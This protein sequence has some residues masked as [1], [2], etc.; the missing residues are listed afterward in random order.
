MRRFRSLS[1]GERGVR[2]VEIMP[3]H[4][5]ETRA[6][7]IMQEEREG[8][9]RRRRPARE[10]RSPDRERERQDSEQLIRD[11]VVYAFEFVQ[12]RYAM[13]ARR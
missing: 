2:Y 10:R 11:A 4:A 6:N 8:S 3:P 9:P 13:R 7:G 12:A 1:C 5:H